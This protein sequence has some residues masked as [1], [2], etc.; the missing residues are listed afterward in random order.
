MLFDDAVWAERAIEE[1][2]AFTQVLRSR[3]VEVL[4]LEELLAETINSPAARLRLVS[5]TLCAIA[6]RPV[7]GSDSSPGSA[8]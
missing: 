5:E 6:A 3:S 2:D 4:Y 1:H 7:L 8:R